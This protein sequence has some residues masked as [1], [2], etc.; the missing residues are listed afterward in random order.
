[1]ISLFWKVFKINRKKKYAMIVKTM[2]RQV[3]MADESFR[4]MS[5]YDAI[6]ITVAK[7]VAM[8]GLIKFF[9]KPKL[10]PTYRITKQKLTVAIVKYDATVPMGAP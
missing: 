4:L 7:S 8:S 2:E 1:M 3:A 10:I 9:K 6:V 5:W